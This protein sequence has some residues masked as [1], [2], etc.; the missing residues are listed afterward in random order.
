MGVMRIGHASLRVMDMAAALKHYEN[1]LGLKVTMEDKNGNVYMKCWDE[2]DKYSLILT[3]S[4]QAG[5]NH[6]A[7]K[8]E[9]E[10]DL[11]ELQAACAQA[12]PQRVGE[13]LG[14][15]GKQTLA[16]RLFRLL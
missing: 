10:S 4:D 6:V 8:C 9:K 5:L 2:W 7:Y 16:K 11:D 13:A 14:C 3:P 1:V 15:E 12:Q